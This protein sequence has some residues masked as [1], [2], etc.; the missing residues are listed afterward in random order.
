MGRTAKSTPPRPPKEAARIAALLRREIVTGALRAG[1][2]LLPERELVEQFGV[3][4]PTMREAMRLLESESLI[5]IS[6]GQHGG[7]RVQSLDVRVTARQLGMFLQMEGTTLADVY[8][9]RSFIEPPAAGLIA[10]RRPLAVIEHLGALIESAKEAYEAQDLKAIAQSAYSFSESLTDNAGN[11]T[12]S[13]MAK[14]LQDIVRRQTT[15]VTLRTHTHEGVRKMQWLS[16]RGRMKLVELI[17][18]GEVEEA[19]KFWR[20][21]LNSTAKVVLSSYRAQ[22]PIDVLQD[23][24]AESA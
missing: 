11:K 19:E 24:D 20:L 1:D 12:L 9:A 2:K 23:P 4:R 13:L 3:S 7:A 5:K 10:E 8:Q 21:H 15:D 17:E 6:R 14:L 18:A 22:M 16:L